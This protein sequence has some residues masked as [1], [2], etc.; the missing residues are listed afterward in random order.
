MREFWHTFHWPPQSMNNIRDVNTNMRFRVDCKSSESTKTILNSHPYFSLDFN[1]TLLSN[2]C[3]LPSCLTHL[4]IKFLF[5]NILNQNQLVSLANRHVEV[6]AWPSSA[7]LLK[8]SYIIK[9]LLNYINLNF[10]YSHPSF[11]SLI[12]FPFS[13]CPVRLVNMMCTQKPRTL[14]DI[15]L[16]RPLVGGLQ[17]ANYMRLLVGGYRFHHYYYGNVCWWTCG[18]TRKVISILFITKTINS[19]KQTTMSQQICAKLLNLFPTPCVYAL[20]V[21]QVFA[22]HHKLRVAA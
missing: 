16:K 5:T 21:Q 13:F 7:K 12:A 8:W 11:I 14:I 10:G 4:Q 22:D 19:P 9:S 15:L 18:L 6:R 17:S 2:K 1:T 20:Y 3:S